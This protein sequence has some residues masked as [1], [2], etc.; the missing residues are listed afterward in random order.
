MSYDGTR[1]KA[2]LVGGGRVRREDM[3]ES[4]LEIEHFYQFSLIHNKVL[5]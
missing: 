4:W 2:V 1:S 3:E 5:Y